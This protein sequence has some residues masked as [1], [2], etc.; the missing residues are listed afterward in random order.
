MVYKP[1]YNWGA[2]SCTI[3]RCTNL[4]GN[5]VKDVIS[6]PPGK[7]VNCLNNEPRDPV[8]LGRAVLCHFDLATV[9]F[10]LRLRT[11]GRKHVD[12]ARREWDGFVLFLYGIKKGLKQ[13]CHTANLQIHD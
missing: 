13:T 7:N 6:R 2:P 8:D 5:M 10:R 1:T 4:N 3:Q 9:A 12:A 11:R